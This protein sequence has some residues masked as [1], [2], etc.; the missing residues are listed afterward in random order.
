M[1]VSRTAF[2]PNGFQQCSEIDKDVKLKEMQIQTSSLET[3]W[4]ASAKHLQM[5]NMTNIP[6]NQVQKMSKNNCKHFTSLSLT[7]QIFDR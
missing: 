4:N 3:S 1:A 6:K 5:K 7:P 2:T